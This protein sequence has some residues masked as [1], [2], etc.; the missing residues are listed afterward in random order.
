MTNTNKVLTA[1]AAGVAVGSILGILFAP[2]KGEQTRKKIA[3]NSRKFSD[4]VKDTITE[5]KNKLANV[6]NNINERI[7]S[8]REEYTS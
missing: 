3:D 2:D 1:L 7:N 8:G 4:S 5:G 6:R